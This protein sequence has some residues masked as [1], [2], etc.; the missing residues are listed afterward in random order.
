MLERLKQKAGVTPAVATFEGGG[1]M[2]INVLNHTLD[3][4][5]G[6]L[7]EIRRTARRGHVSSAGGGRRRAAAAV[8]GRRDGQGAGHRSRRCASSAGSPVRRARRRRHRAWEAADPEAARRPGV[9]ASSTPPTAF[10]PASCRT[11]STSVHGRVRQGDRSVPQGV[12]RH[13]VKHR[14]LAFGSAALALSVGLLLDG[15][16]A[17]PVSQLADAIG[18]QGLPK[19]RVLL[20]GLSLI[21]DRRDRCPRSGSAK[22]HAPDSPDPEP[23]IRDRVVRAAGMLLHR[24]CVHRCS[25]RGSATCC[26]LPG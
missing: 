25:C 4:G 21:S 13:R 26:R 11:P 14:D 15:D 24:R 16:A 20:A 17:V 9:Q 7:Q 22:R 5:I 1:D 12:R 18:P 6:E 19:I 3:M 23:L 10:S 2:L 8:S